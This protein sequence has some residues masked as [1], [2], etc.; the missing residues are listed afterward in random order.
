V[1]LK[2]EMSAS[3]A[4]VKRYGAFF[5]DKNL[6]TM[7]DE[8]VTAKVGTQQ[9]HVSDLKTL[10][11]G[12][13]LNDTVVDLMTQVLATVAMH[14]TDRK[15]AVFDSQFTKLILETPQGGRVWREIEVKI[16]FFFEEFSLDTAGREE[17]DLK[18][19]EFDVRGSIRHIPDEFTEAG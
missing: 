1:D 4:L 18:V 13:R 11:P 10:A 6:K 3:K 16:K 2:E 8:K 14:G 9:L 12:T 7:Q 19:K 17:R 15:V 5:T